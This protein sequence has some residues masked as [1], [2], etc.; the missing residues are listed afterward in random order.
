MTINCG[1]ATL[2]AGIDNLSVTFDQPYS[3]PPTIVLTAT[4]I[5]GG[6]STN[7]Y[8]S[9][10]TVTNFKINVSNAGASVDVHWHAMS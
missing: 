4:K 8:V 10:V 6:G 1:I 7:A 5:E 3:S 2:G 9:D